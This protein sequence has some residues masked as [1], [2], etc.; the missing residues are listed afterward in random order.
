M[1]ITYRESPWHPRHDEPL[2]MDNL[3]PKLGKLKPNGD[4][5]QE[6][7]R[8]FCLSLTA[9]RI[10]ASSWW[11]G[12]SIALLILSRLSRSIQSACFDQSDV[13]MNRNQGRQS[14]F[15]AAA[16]PILEIPCLGVVKRRS[17]MCF[18]HLPTLSTSFFKTVH[19]QYFN[20]AG[21]LMPSNQI[22]CESGR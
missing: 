4:L 13:P 15:W 1:N 7:S 17:A 3:F 14:L 20:T 21:S 11:R 12:W 22:W 2:V 10:R 5:Y 6:L 8:R 9:L 19:T 16:L 18:H